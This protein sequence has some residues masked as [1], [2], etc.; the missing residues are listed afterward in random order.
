MR[1]DLAGV[2]A[3]DLHIAEGH[4]PDFDYPVALGHELCGVL[5]HVGGDFGPDVRGRHLE[6]GQRVAVMPATPCGRCRACRAAGPVPACDGWDV[7][8]FSNPSQRPAG[9]G[10]GQYVTAPAPA[11][12][13]VTEA[14]PEVAVLAEPAATPVEG[15]LRA[16][17]RL[18]DSV[19]VQGTGTVGLLAV[20]VVVTGGA[21]R[22]VAIGGPARRLELARALGAVATVDI[23]DLHDLDDRRNVV[24]DASPG[25]RG[26][27]LVVE[28]AGVPS[29]VPE[30]LGYLA[31]G[32]TFLELGHFSDAGDVAINP[33]RHLLSRDARVI[34]SSG[35]T[36]GAFGRALGLCERLGTD[37]AQLI[38]HR[39]PLERAGD[40]LHALTP[41]G[42][43]RLDGDEVGK[44]VIDPWR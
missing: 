4:V 8:G 5:E 35:Y 13:F 19:L 1:V 7:L 21:S 14:P 27:D 30:G 41:D 31:S 38:T 12:L 20:A 32:G 25:G 3:T 15:L 39:L 26:Y 6:P 11:R 29:T 40:A 44:L 34:A 24:L 23:A 17:F 18:G 16:G 28:C 43:W 36:P 9:G 42:G 2:C 22:V 37:V 10:W 33:Y